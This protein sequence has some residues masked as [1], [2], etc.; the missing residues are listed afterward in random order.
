MFVTDAGLE[1]GDFSRRLLAG[2]D[3]LRN[4]LKAM[5]E[6]L[7]SRA[8]PEHFLMALLRWPDSG[9]VAMCGTLRVDVTRLADGLARS[10]RGAAVGVK[11]AFGPDTLSPGAVAGLKKLEALCAGQTDLDGRQ[12]HLLAAAMIENC[13]SR[14]QHVFE[15]AGVPVQGL[16]DDLTHE[17][18]VIEPF[19]ADGSLSQAA[20]DRGAMKVLVRA[21]TEGRALGMEAFNTQLLLLALVGQE[22]GLAGRALRMQQVSPV[23]I[24][25]ALLLRLRALGKRKQLSELTLLVGQMQQKVQQVIRAAAKDAEKLRQERID[26]GHLLR[27]LVKEDPFLSAGILREHK[28]DLPELE[29]YAMSRRDEAAEAPPEAPPA[30]V[31]EVVQGLRQRIIGQDHVIQAMEPLLK[32]LRFGYVRKNKPMGV[33]LFLGSSGT[34]KTEM[35]KGL[36]R[37]LYGSEDQMIFLEMGQFGSEY[38][39]SMFIGAPPGYKGYGEGQLTNG[40]R[41]KPEAVILFDEVEKAHEAVFDVLLRFLD[42]GVIADPAGPVRDGRKCLIILTSNLRL[43][44]VCRLCW[45]S[46]SACGPGGSGDLPTLK[47]LY[48]QDPHRR[49]ATV[50]E[51]IKKISFFRPE[52]LNRVDEVV[53]FKDLA[54][55][56]FAAIARKELRGEMERFQEE[57]GREILCGQEV[58][59]TIAERCADRWEEGARVVGK[60]ISADVIAPIIDF[61][62]TPGNESC[63]RAQVTIGEGK[64]RVTPA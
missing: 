10:V 58:L 21:E 49:Q 62:V 46:D 19:E 61:F 53:L 50:R 54:R 59:E 17:V 6:T 30:S 39:K 35:A 43:E 34:G 13:S 1:I 22:D 51:A 48:S 2:T 32:R 45:E 5:N 25:D 27:A 20:F 26:E 28:V 33:F 38:D 60:V 18:H 14:G 47:E 9:L 31:D 40:L 64:T 44:G 36:A 42:E 16:V 8:L 41:D 56:D 7:C 11:E 37:L 57:K 12:D 4:V 3:E 24:Y 52:F 23:V 15:Y 55:A 29:A 63:H